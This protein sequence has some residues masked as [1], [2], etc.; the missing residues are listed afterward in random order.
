MVDY[1]ILCQEIEAEYEA[2]LENP[3]RSLEVLYEK[4]SEYLKWVI[5]LHMK[6]GIFL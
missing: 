4:L 2:Y 5:T 1:T 6:K 3:N